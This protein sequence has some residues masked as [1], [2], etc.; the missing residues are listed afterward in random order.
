MTSEKICKSVVMRRERE[1]VKYVTVC[2]GVFLS[3]ENMNEFWVGKEDKQKLGPW[4]RHGRE[5]W[6]SGTS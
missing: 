2:C 4:S 5:E 3:H 6:Y 1:G